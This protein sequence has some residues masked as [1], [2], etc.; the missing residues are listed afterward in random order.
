[1]EKYVYKN[2]GILHLNFLQEATYHATETGYVT[3]EF[4]WSHAS[5][6]NGTE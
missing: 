5:V 2:P 3:M 1:M 4:D 6:L